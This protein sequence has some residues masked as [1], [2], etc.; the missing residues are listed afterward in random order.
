M[1][2]AAKLDP[3]PSLPPGVLRFLLWLQKTEGRDKLYR[4]VVYASKFVVDSLLTYSAQPPMDVVQRLERGASVVATSRKLFRMFRSL[5]STARTTS[6]RTPTAQHASD[7]QVVRLLL[8]LPHQFVVLTSLLCPLLLCRYLQD[9]LASFALADPLERAASSL[10]GCS[11]SLWLLCDHIQWLTKVGCL[12]LQPHTLKR[13]DAYHSQAWFSGL[14]FAA[15]LALYRLQQLVKQEQ[16]IVTAAAANNSATPVAQRQLAAIQHK[17][18]KHIID[19]VKN[20][21]DLIIPAARLGWI[22]A[23]G[24]TV[25]LAGTITSLIGIYQTYPAKE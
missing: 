23:S 10:K 25:G 18:A 19:V 20:G 14:L 16:P 7:W 5:E 17:K 1:S 13:L 4:L 9:A 15:L 8:P 22:D 11:L 3:A 21:T 2:S 6:H 12:R 24:Q